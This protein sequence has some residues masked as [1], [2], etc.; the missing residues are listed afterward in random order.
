M[1]YGS[2][3]SSEPAGSM[4]LSVLNLESPAG[5]LQK[6]GFDCAY[7]RRTKR[8]LFQNGFSEAQVFGRSVI[9]VDTLLLCFLDPS[10]EQPVSTWCSRTVNKLFPTSPLPVRLA[11]TWLLT[12]V[13]RVSACPGPCTAWGV[14]VT[15]SLLASISYGRQ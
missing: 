5:A 8:E 12:K 10:D 7:Y 13:M 9:D 4:N 11:S 1:N 14:L 6:F 15:D 2:E 3:P